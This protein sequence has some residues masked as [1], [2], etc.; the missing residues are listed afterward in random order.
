MKAVIKN[1]SETFAFAEKFSAGLKK[2]DVI[3][4][5]GELGA[6]KTYFVQGLARGLKISKKYY[7]NSPTFAILNVYEGGKMPVYHFDWYRLGDVREVLDLGI[8]EYID[9][10]GLTVIEWAE[11]FKELLPKRTI[12]IRMEVVDEDKRVISIENAGFP[13]SRE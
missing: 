6:G 12:W 13:P 1:L 3:A 9:S 4:L 8:E 11:K 7:V 10:K 5:T 2:G